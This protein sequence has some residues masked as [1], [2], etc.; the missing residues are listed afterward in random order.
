MAMPFNPAFADALDNPERRRALPI[1]EILRYL[2]A[3]KMERKVAVDI[4]AGTGYL[5]VPLSWAFERV[6]AVEANSKMAE[7]LRENIEGRGIANVEIILS[8]KPPELPE[9]PN[10]VAFSLSLH[11]VGDWRGY[12]RWASMADYVLVIEWC[13]ESERGPPREEKIPREELIELEDFEVVLSR[14]R[15]PYY[16]VILRPVRR[17]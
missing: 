8:E 14:V 9:R 13:P 2:L 16:L 4:G 15:F 7:L 11:E 6:Y 12:L 10:L 3:L 17:G 1:K 5:T